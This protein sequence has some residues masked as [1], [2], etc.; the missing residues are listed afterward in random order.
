[1]VD[2]LPPIP[3]GYSLQE[4]SSQNLPP[5]PEGYRVQEPQQESSLSPYKKSALGFATGVG[6]GAP[7]GQDI[8]A[9]IATGLSYTP[10]H[11]QYV[12]TEGSPLE[13]YETA[14]RAQMQAADIAAE[15]A[16][17]A[18][19]VGT[20]TGI[21]GS[22]PAFEFAAPLEAGVTAKAAPYIGNAASKA[23]GLGTSGTAIGAV[24]GLG[25]GVTPEEHLQSALSGAKTGA[26]L[27]V[28]LPTLGKGL[29]YATGLGRFTEAEKAAEALGAQMPASVSSKHPITK[30]VSQAFSVSPFTKEIMASGVKKGEEALGEAL[31]NKSGLTHGLNETTAGLNARQALLKWMGQDSSDYLTKNY[32]NKVERLINPRTTAPMTQLNKALNSIQSQKI[33]AK[34]PE[35]KGIFTKL[36]AAA[37]DPKGLT[38]DDAQY[39]KRFV[40]NQLTKKVADRKI[41]ESEKNFIYGAL[42]EDVRN[43][44]KKAGASGG[45]GG[46]NRALKAFDEATLE[47]QK[48]INDRKMLMDI[49]GR[50]GDA[51]GED[52]FLT[53]ANAARSS[54]RGNEELLKKARERMAP[55]AWRDLASVITENMGKTPSGFSSKEFVDSFHKMSDAAKDALYGPAGNPMRKAIEDVYT[56]S[57]E[58]VDNKK[59]N[60]YSKLALAVLGGVGLGLPLLH[61]W[62]AETAGAEVAGALT[63][64]PMAV[65][66][67]NPRW[68]H[69]FA[70]VMAKPDPQLIKSFQDTLR[71]ELIKKYGKPKEQRMESE[72]RTTRAAGGKIGKK[73]YPA[74]RLTRMERAVKRAQEAIAL[75]TRPIMNMPDEAVAQALHL[76]KDK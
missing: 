53:L 56:V 62:N 22:L 25:E 37:T 70:R 33:A 7:F 11:P 18:S 16:P 10:F 59:Q 47:G 27:N 36:E 2:D 24:S 51:T 48:I 46:G 74:K 4:Q 6:R 49:V 40:G 58:Y 72:P 30:F 9:A 42:R 29:S 31:I 21:A 43:I 13:R 8:P 35:A 23:L 28:G 50:Q 75:E 65:I 14:K 69:G 41:S 1:M 12:P 26:L 15:Q 73:D 19:G 68:A 57:K 39:L 76:A 34:L 45:G 60:T 61:G 44:V 55:D 52:V 20:L 32:Y 38:Y 63:T 64:L 66:L 67:S 3:E 71:L 17:V 5:I 54:G